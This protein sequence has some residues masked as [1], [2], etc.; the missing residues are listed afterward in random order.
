MGKLINLT[1]KK[2]GRLFV[3]GR[4]ENDRHGKPMWKCRCDCGKLLAVRGAA[5]LSGHTV[6]CGCYCRDLHRK[7]G[8][9]GTRLYAVWASMKARCL[10]ESHK[11]Y[12]DYGG[13]GIDV[14][15]N[16]LDFKNFKD[17]AIK[18]GYDIGSPKWV[19]TLD[20]IDVNKGYFPENCRWVNMD[21]Q[22]SNKRN[23]LEVEY[24]GE[25]HTLR[26]W[27]K[28]LDISYQTLYARV[29]R[30]GCSLDGTKIAE[31]NL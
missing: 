30:Y 15:D 13:R 25:K 31:R 21:E 16:W 27:S 7:H 18:A 22:G 4:T 28:I 20:R 12:P 23:K 14:C 1:N 19:C 26:E 2:F 5:L 3:I 24:N 10:N 8:C 29:K 6:S 17:W 11:A 9:E